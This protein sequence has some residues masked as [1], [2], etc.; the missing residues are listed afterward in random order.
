MSATLTMT[1]STSTSS[2]L[3]PCGARAAATRVAAAGPAA[4]AGANDG[5]SSPLSLQ[6]SGWPAAR[7]QPLPASSGSGDEAGQWTPVG[8]RAGLFFTL[9]TPRCPLAFEQRGSRGQGAQPMSIPTKAL[10]DNARTP[11]S[12]RSVDVFYAA[13]CSAGR[14]SPWTSLGLLIASIRATAPE[15]A[16]QHPSFPT[17][18]FAFATKPPLGLLAQSRLHAV[19]HDRADANGAIAPSSAR[20]PRLVDRAWSSALPEFRR[21][22]T[23]AREAT[24]QIKRARLARQAGRRVIIAQGQV[25]NHQIVVMSPDQSADT[26]TQAA[27]GQQC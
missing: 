8:S 24:S 5:S 13:S 21:D 22:Q 1:A 26:P 19:D 7:G 27:L 15:R 20:R 3:L 10:W 9:Q 18:S 14:S 4:A 6:R 17:S 11:R 12:G 16:R 23:S 2:V 25:V